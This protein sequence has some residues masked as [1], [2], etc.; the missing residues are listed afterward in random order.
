MS[1]QVYSVNGYGQTSRIFHVQDETDKK[2]AF[3][4]ISA[5]NSNFAPD[6]EHLKEL[7]IHY[8]TLALK[9]DNTEVPSDQVI[10]R[11]NKNLG[12]HWRTFMLNTDFY[13][14]IDW[15]RYVLINRHY[16]YG[17]GIPFILVAKNPDKYRWL[18]TYWDNL[19]KSEGEQSDFAR[20]VDEV[21]NLL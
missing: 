21:A 13:N 6:W 12:D 20:L 8:N 17:G 16:C 1:K 11:I 10:E 15:E 19:V 5:L 7:R 4:K 2:S 14:E 3:I 18:K 9:D